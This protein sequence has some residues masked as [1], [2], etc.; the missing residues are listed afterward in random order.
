MS[1]GAARLVRL[2]AW[3]TLV[4]IVATA[5]AP[6]GART[7]PPDPAQLAEQLEAALRA[8]RLP[9][10]SAAVVR[11]D[12]TL[13][14]GGV[15]RDG[16]GG[17]VTADTR[18]RVA[19]LSKSFTAVGVLQL[20][21]AGRIRLDAPVQ[22]Q[23]PEFTTSD[24]GAAARVTVRQLLDQTSGLADS[25]LPRG[26]DDRARDL[27]ARVAEL[28]TAHLVDEPGSRFHYSDLNY[29][30]LGRLVEV[31]S[32]TS[33]DRYLH[34]HVFGPLGMAST[35]SVATA[36]AGAELSGLARGHV[37]LYGWPVARD[38][39]EGLLAGSSGVITTAADMTRWL[40][41]Q[42]TG[43]TPAGVA[44]L[45]PAL[46][47]LTHR[48]P[49]GSVSCYAMGWQVTRGA[50]DDPARLEHTG[51]LS[52]SFAHQVL[53]PESGGAFALLYNGNS[54]LADTAGVAEGVAATLTGTEAPAVRGTR[55]TAGLLAALGLA[56]L[57]AGVR[58]VRRSARWAARRRA[59]RRWTTAVR[60]AL[61]LLPAVA[62][63]FL[64]GLLR[65]AIDRSFTL[66]QLTLAAPDAVILLVVVGL[67][68]VA[69]SAV[70]ARAVVLQHAA[71]RS[72]DPREQPGRRPR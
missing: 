18:F 24:P 30:V 44:L 45:R 17:R 58:G 34:E 7:P 66:W 26:V 39:L 15:G 65:A 68:G 16:H 70:R 35:V 5:G 38:E 13:Y 53:L 64:P 48:P 37:L 22:G 46:L 52:T 9:G 23:L 67:T 3:V 21:Q 20:V 59:G 61:P 27:A 10:V 51:V 12:R 41:F 11:G 28:R 36:A 69:V 2:L 4:L 14:A 47:D 19:S 40:T 25:S 57:A 72:A 55:P 63:P 1:S 33:L 43:R 54:A 31:V 8:T 29:Q 62:L 56:V 42:T 50:C 71:T 6:A 60:L 32:G 49:E